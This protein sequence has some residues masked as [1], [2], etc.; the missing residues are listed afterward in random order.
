MKYTYFVVVKSNMFGRTPSTTSEIIDLDFKINSAD[1]K[2]KVEDLF[3]I[4]ITNDANPEKPETVCL[5]N[6]K[7]LSE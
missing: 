2:Q 1:A 3:K 4:N 5:V 7:L 6:F